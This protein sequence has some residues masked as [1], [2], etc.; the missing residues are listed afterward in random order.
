MILHGFSHFYKNTEEHETLI[1]W[2]ATRSCSVTLS[3]NHLT[4]NSIYRKTPIGIYIYSATA[5]AFHTFRNLYIYAL[6]Q[7]RI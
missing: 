4:S 1:G 6:L 5:T 7:A 2:T 3:K